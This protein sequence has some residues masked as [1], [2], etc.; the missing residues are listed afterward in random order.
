MLQQWAR[1]YERVAH[2]HYTAYRRARIRAFYKHGV[3]KL[4]I[5]YAIEVLVG[6]L[7]IS[8]FLFFAGLSVYLFSIHRTIFKAVTAW[9]GVCT[10]FYTCITFLPVIR[11]DS[12]YTAPL[13]T[14]FSF[15]L[16]GIRYNFFRVLQRF[17][18]IDPA[19][20]MPFR[21]RDQGEVHL[22]DFFSHSMSK[23][24]EEYAFKMSPS[25]DYDSLLWTLESLD[26]DA[27]LE[28]FFEGFPGLCDSET[29][30]KLNVQ[31]GFIVPFKNKLS[32]ALIGLMNR[33][34]SS[35]LVSEFV[36]QR[37][38]IICIKAIEST[39]L[40]G[41]WWILRRVLLGGWHQFLGCI[42]FGLFVRDWDI[43]HKVT[44]FYA[45]CVTVLTIS[46]VRD[47]DGRWYQLAS[48][49]LDVSKSL[50]N[51]YIANGDSI[52]LANAILIV[53]RTVQTYPGSEERHKNDIIGA[54]SKT[55][56]T[57]CKLDIGRT[58]PELQH[59]FCGLWNQLVYVAQTDTR[60]PQVCVAKT[61]LKNIR[62]LYIALHECSTT[63]PKAFYTT[64]NDRDPILDNPKSYP[65][66]SIN[67]HRPFEPLPDLQFDEPTP[68]TAGDVPPTP[69]MQMPIPFAYPPHRPSAV[70]TTFTPSP[71]YTLSS[72]AHYRPRY[73]DTYSHSSAPPRDAV[74]SFPQ[75]Q[76]TPHASN[77]QPGVVVRSPPSPMSTSVPEVYVENAS[78]SSSSE[79][80]EGHVPQTP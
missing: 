43:S 68:D 52:L 27:D 16:T 66:C 54:S 9:I 65:T 42:E 30:K 62:K 40:I 63:P 73:V 23:T 48:D 26:E 7:H 69:G 35:N 33:T 76:F 45:Q 60:R 38:M 72:P 28:K 29:G 47:H 8:L 11:K 4:R 1:R 55:L 44:S 71:P 17:P 37:R 53:R 15:F 80:S 46:I 18:D 57:V 20:F 32:N 19:K 49:L 56:E 61:T 79:S 70:P 5:P 3:D 41:P 2:P 77:V 12:P 74:F 21:S 22:D 67:D 34:M 75:P 6:L 25:I 14:S 24:A 59:E 78:T 64:T 13:S 51:K 39:S 10:I 58:F 31:Q 36:K 50:L